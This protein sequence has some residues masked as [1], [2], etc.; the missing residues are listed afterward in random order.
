MPKPDMTI[1]PHADCVGATAC[2]GCRHRGQDVPACPQ[3]AVVAHP[4]GYS[5]HRDRP[6]DAYSDMDRCE[7][8]SI[9]ARRKISQL[10]PQCTD[11]RAGDGMLTICSGTL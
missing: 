6:P 10:R 5:A 2:H 1:D 4:T 11:T 3:I 9:S 8:I 7:I